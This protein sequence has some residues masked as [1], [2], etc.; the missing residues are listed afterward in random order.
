M[1]VFY[2]VSL[3]WSSDGPN[4]I[5]SRAFIRVNRGSALFFVHSLS[6][7]SGSDHFSFPLFFL[8]ASIGRFVFLIKTSLRVDK[9][10]LLKP[11]VTFASLVT[12]TS[13]N[14]ISAFQN[15]STF[16]RQKPTPL[17]TCCNLC[18]PCGS[19]Q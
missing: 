6:S 1:G 19:N 12:P 10:H 13:N 17:K 8:F 4:P 11:A 14:G 5:L 7:V 2:L 18:Q 9:S 3:W 16:I 15:K